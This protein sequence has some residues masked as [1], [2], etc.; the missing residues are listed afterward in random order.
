MQAKTKFILY[1]VVLTIIGLSILGKMR[2]S[3]AS[4]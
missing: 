4:S 2:M 1:G 3:E